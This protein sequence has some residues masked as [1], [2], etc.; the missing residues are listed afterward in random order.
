MLD[1]GVVHRGRAQGACRA[2]RDGVGP[3]HKL[4]P[5]RLMLDAMFHKVR[6]RCRWQDLPERFGPWKGV[7][8][9][10]EKWRTCEVW[11][12]IMAA[13]PVDGPGYRPMPE[14]NL[15]L[16][17]RVEGRVD[18]RVLTG[19]EEEVVAPE[20]RCPPPPHQPRARHS[21]RWGRSSPSV[22]SRPWPG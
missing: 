5:G 12:E 18:P 6:T 9:R 4:I 3:N 15:V 19:A 17:F 16:P 21:G 11:D 10:Y 1:G 14:L 7:H 13:L 2:D 22:V 8:T 20:S